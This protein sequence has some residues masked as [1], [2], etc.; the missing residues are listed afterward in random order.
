MLRL[1]LDDVSGAFLSTT[2][3]DS[4]VVLGGSSQSAS[5]SLIINF[6]Y[7]Q[8]ATADNLPAKPTAPDSMKS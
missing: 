2:K 4:V 8:K 7:L 6:L 5:D 3:N 1:L